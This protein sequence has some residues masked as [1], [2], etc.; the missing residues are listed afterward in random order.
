[1]KPIKTD[2]DHQAA[3]AEIERLAVENP[4]PGTE[5]GDRLEI[6]ATLVEA[7]E[8]NHFPIEKPTPAEAVEFRMDQIGL[9]QKDLE[10]YIGSRSRVSEVLSGKRPLTLRMIR[11]LSKGLGI[12]SEVLL[13]ELPRAL[14]PDLQIDWQKFPLYEMSR[15]GWIESRPDEIGGHEEELMRSF[16][17][18]VEDEELLSVLYRTTEF[19]ERSGRRMDP[20]ALVAWSAR[21]L[22]LAKNQQVERYVPG[23]ATGE[24]MRNV[25]RCSWADKGP[26]LAQEYL[27]NHGIHV[28]IE[29][30]LPR[31]YLDGSA[32]LM[33]KKRSP[34]IG[35]TIR[36]DRLD[37]FWFVLLHE[38]GHI[39]AHLD[40]ETDRTA[41]SFFDDL[42]ME[43]Q[44]KKE[45]EADRLAQDALIPTIA[46]KKFMAEPPTPGR[47]AALATALTIHPAIVAGR[48]RHE[49]KH[50][51]R[52]SRMV[53]RHGVRR[54][55]PEI[56]SSWT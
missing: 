30:H 23:T 15:R 50:Y 24:F 13:Q 35:M 33:M 44:D 1:M 12:P 5:D 45:Q 18:P 43:S 8:K 20:Y 55:F 40:V 48:Y 42:D 10:V 28:I 9:K 38:L 47:I 31:T 34:V 53:G 14:P 16:F 37:N 27:A 29:P 4:A 51:R 36:H 26:L 52:F 6:L 19:A 25:A 3:L 7:Y 2:A 22:M 46:W 32:C 39:A 41:R 11:A 54:L 49:T 21:V 56:A 17:A